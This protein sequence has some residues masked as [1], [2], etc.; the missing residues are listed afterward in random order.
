LPT[1]KNSKNFCK[2]KRNLNDYKTDYLTFLADAKEPGDPTEEGAAKRMIIYLK[3]DG[4]YH[5]WD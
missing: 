2:D 1:N 4:L 3:E 5:K